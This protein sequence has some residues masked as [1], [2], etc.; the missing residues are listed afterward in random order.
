MSAIDRDALVH[1]LSELD[2]TAYR[3]GKSAAL[4]G[5]NLTDYADQI[6]A[7]L[8]P[9]EASVLSREDIRRA[10]A[11]IL[12]NTS[13]YPRRAQPYILGQDIAPL[14]DRVINAVVARL[15]EVRS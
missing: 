11:P 12:W 1:I 8:R 4:P 6:L 15:D 10:V 13:N 7:L 9:V 5:P 14:T 2:V 3:H